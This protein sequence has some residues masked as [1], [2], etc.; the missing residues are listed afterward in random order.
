MQAS[1]ARGV[2]HI[3]EVILLVALYVLNCRLRVS[4]PWPFY[5]TVVQF[6]RQ[7]KQS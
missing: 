7:T 6:T 3:E 1:F 5:C 2:V 4:Q